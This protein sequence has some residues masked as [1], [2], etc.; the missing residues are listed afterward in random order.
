MWEGPRLGQGATEP[1]TLHR[2]TRERPLMGE[3]TPTFSLFR[4]NPESS[5]GIGWALPE[6]QAELRQVLLEGEFI[7]KLGT[8]VG[9]QP[10]G[11]GCVYTSPVRADEKQAPIRTNGGE[12]GCAHRLALCRPGWAGRGLGWVQTDA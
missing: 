8:V 12:N 7:F 4:L 5:S 2:E 3:G 9:K 1:V 6:G 10:G 11:S